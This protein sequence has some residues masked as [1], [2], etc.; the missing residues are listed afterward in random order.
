MEHKT[1]VSVVIPFYNCPYVNLA[2]ESVLAQSY[3]DIELIVVDDG[4]TLYMEKLEAY[5]NQMVYIRKPNGGTASALNRGIQV[6]SGAYFAWLSA[7]DLFHPDKIRRQ[8]ET[9]RSS[10]TFFNHT[11]YYY[12]NA[13]GERFSGIIRMPA[14]T[15]QAFIQTMMSSCPVNGSTVLCD[16]EIFSRI[17]LF[18]ES[19]LYTQDYDLWLRILPHFEW[20]YIDEPLLDY[21]VHNE[22]GSVLHS[23]AQRREIA[24]VQ[25]MH[26][27]NLTRLLR[28]ERST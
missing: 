19:L 8:M 9:I 17:G 23:E 22:M 16:M 14:F 21:R 13:L 26:R 27:G 3:T 18:N 12:I 7:D 5:K 10:G 20:S 11:A 15:R 6:S 4:S 24:Q 25:S 2:V 1:K 28:K